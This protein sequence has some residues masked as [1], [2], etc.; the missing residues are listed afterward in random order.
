LNLHW[1]EES[2]DRGLQ[3]AT[4]VAEPDVELA[5]ARFVLRGSAGRLHARRD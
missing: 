1:H 3:I 4:A 5:E 2:R